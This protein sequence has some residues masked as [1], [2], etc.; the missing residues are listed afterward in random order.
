MLG[1]KMYSLCC[2]ISSTAFRH[3]IDLLDQ[4]RVDLLPTDSLNHSEMLQVIMRL[5]QGIA[6]EELHKNTAN[7]PD[8][9]R[10]R[11]PKTK[12][13]F[14]GPIMSSGHDWRV[15][16]ILKCCWAEVDKPNLGVKQDF[17]LR[18]LSIDCSRWWWDST[19]VGE[20]LVGTVTE[21]DIFRLQISMDQVK[22]V[23]D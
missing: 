4:G 21:K 19:A 14:G 17:A 9:T 5:K 10:E 15:V 11:P 13:D 16:L 3:L 22:I 8:V 7:T 23:Q 2:W 6:R 1:H 12:D 20:S 18:S